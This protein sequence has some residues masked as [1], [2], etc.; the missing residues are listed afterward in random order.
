MADCSG[1]PSLAAQ[2]TEQGLRVRDEAGRAQGHR[3][4]ECCHCS[5]VP[6]HGGTVAQISRFLH[7]LREAPN[8]LFL[9][10]MFI[11]LQFSFLLTANSYSEKLRESAVFEAK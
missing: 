2:V 1:H 7:V 4:E 3:P 9:N 8:L 5:G 10:K 6:S 11:L